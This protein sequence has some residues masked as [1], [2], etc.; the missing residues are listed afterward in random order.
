[1]RTFTV[2]EYDKEDY[3]AAKAEIDNMSN[4]ELAN[5]LSSIGRGY[6]GD[7]NFTGKED[8][9]EN[10]KLHMIIYKIVEILKGDKNGKD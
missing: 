2:I 6:V 7:Y 4:E 3:D 8:D 9:F 5:A 1:M 10:Y